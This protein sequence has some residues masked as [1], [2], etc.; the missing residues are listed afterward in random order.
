MANVPGILVPNDLVA[1]PA[2]RENSRYNTKGLSVGTPGQGSTLNN[3]DNVDPAWQTATVDETHWN[4]SYPFQLL[5][6]EQGDE[7]YIEHT[8]QNFTLPI[9]PQALTIST[10][11]AVTGSVT[12]GG[13]LEEHNGSPIRLINL[14]GTTGVTPNRGTATQAKSFGLGG[15]IL[16]G[17]ISGFQ[18]VG[19]AIRQSATGPTAL[20]KP[21]LIT[22]S[23]IATEGGVKHTTG[24]FQF[25][26][27]RSYLESYM[28]LKKTKAGQKFRLALAIWKDNEAYLVT[29][30]SFDLSRSAQSPLE[31]TYTI[32]FRAFRRWVPK[33]GR[34]AANGHRPVVRDP[35]ALA[36][37]LG[38][39]Q[40]ARRALQ[41]LKGVLTGF[42]ADVDAV[43]FGPVREIGLFAKDILG[44]GLT[45]LDLPVNIIRDM[46]DTIVQVS[47][48]N[49]DVEVLRRGNGGRV[50]AEIADLRLKLRN[51]STISG[52]AETGADPLRSENLSQQRQALGGAGGLGA[53]EADPANKL[54]DDPDKNPDLFSS[55]SIGSLNVRP[56]V[57]RR[58][59]EERRRVQALTRLDF[60]KRRDAIIKLSADYADF[61]GAGSTIFAS[62]YGRAAPVSTRTPTDDDWEVL[63]QLNQ[64]IMEFNRI[65][66]STA[67]D[68]RQRLTAMEYIA[69]QASVVGIPF[70]VPA[71]AFSVPFPFGSTL[72]MV[73][74]HYLGDADR[75]HEIAVLNN[76]RAPWVDEEGFTGPLLVNGSGNNVQV[77]AIT[78][79]V[80]GQS[81]WISSNDQIR[82]KR[83]I[84]AI[85]TLSPAI[86]LVTV[87]GVGD[88]GRFTVSAQAEIFAFMPGTVNSLQLLYLPNDQPPRDQNLEPRPNPSIDEFDSLLQVGGADLLLTSS[89]DLAITKDGDCRLAVGLSNLIQ[90]VRLAL[91]T[92]LGTLQRH[93][94]YGFGVQPGVSTADISAADILAAA[95][96]TFSGDPAFTGIV[97]ASVN[98]NG[99]GL[100]IGMNL[101]IAGYSQLVP[102]VFKVRR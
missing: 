90:V 69:G 20:F 2:I 5:L 61:I 40:A 56:A 34:P 72:E 50:R 95:R 51:L 55:M 59:I 88:L 78:N 38:R 3:A 44:V 4:R 26:M 54:F 70:K 76:L 62:T 49:N 25:M 84:T 18:R 101:G 1:S 86:H 48:V 92:P 98:K 91:D 68:D 10:P 14:Q 27:L 85:R 60:E 96:S 83:R 22:D 13:Y 79:L 57:A 19:A 64:T 12:L 30:M 16:G 15:A 73:A 66:A 45:A 100:S 75:W 31:Y 11:F 46:K 93:P 32:Q 36:A 23:D 47:S 43:V 74:A 52:I 6:L 39:V 63:F 37:M 94:E 97:S 71:S 65:T 99:P 80:V 82:E 77:A 29:P 21:N 81:L 41:G 53:N 102:M 58:I 9:P 33:Q 42:R 35:N 17:T 87:D 24:Y 7:D 89:G 28:N 8:G 67:S